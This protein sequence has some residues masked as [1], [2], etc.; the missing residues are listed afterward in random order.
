MV[1]S[2]FAN[3]APVGASAAPCLETK[4]PSVVLDLAVDIGPSVIETTTVGSGAVTLGCR[5]QTGNQVT[6]GVVATPVH[7]EQTWRAPTAH[8]N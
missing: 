2:I 6:T 8:Q 7:P 1:A 3:F 5:R 4:W